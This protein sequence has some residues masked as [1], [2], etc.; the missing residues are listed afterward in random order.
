MTAKLIAI[1]PKKYLQDQWNWLDGGVVCLSLVEIVT[2]IMGSSGGNLSAFSTIRVLRTFRILRVARLL[3]ALKSMK[4]ILAVILGSAQSF[5]MITLLMFVFVFIYT[6]L[7]MQLF[8]NMFN[9]EDGKP[10][11]NF[12][13]FGIGFFTVFQV[14]TT[15]NWNSVL[16]DSMRSE[17]M[18]FVAP[19]YY[20]TWIFIG[21][22]ILLNLFLAILLDGFM[23]AGQDEDDDSEEM[24]ALE[25]ERR[26]KQIE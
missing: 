7:G 5:I 6:L 19:V 16:Y 14:M 8:G 25:R 26:K 24:I 15:E 17:A 18:K 10:R 9:F 22:F 20:I 4:V 2:K 3:R 13:S 1:G 21:N 23:T 12:D 11:G